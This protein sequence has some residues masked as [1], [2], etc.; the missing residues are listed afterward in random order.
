MQ[1]RSND[2]TVVN[3]I[4]LYI[5]DL[6]RCPPEKVVDVLR[7]IHL[8]LAFRLFVVVVA[9]DARW[10]KRSLK[11]RFSLMLGAPGTVQQRP[12]ARP[13]E[14]PAGARFIA[15]DRFSG[16]LPRKDFSG[17]VLDP[18]ARPVRISP[19]RYGANPP[20][21]RSRS[22]ST[23]S[24][25]EGRRSTGNASNGIDTHAGG[26][27]TVIGEQRWRS[28]G[29]GSASQQK[30][31]TSGPQGVSAEQADG[32]LRSPTCWS[33]ARSNRSRVR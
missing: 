20:R 19:A 5:D 9:V 25:F 27:H 24:D 31:A 33:G 6:D 3:R 30:Q 12:T 2:P 15:W 1:T 21:H 4:I 28:G 18:A 16:R 13:A 14:I 8:L 32:F 11:D 22:V 17:T 7:A 26:E 10:M 29:G 23:Q